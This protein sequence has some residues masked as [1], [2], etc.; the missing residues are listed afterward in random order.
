MLKHFNMER[1]RLTRFWTHFLTEAGISKPI[2]AD[3]ATSFS[4]H[5]IQENMI[6]NLNEEC[7]RDLGINYVGD[8]MAIHKHAQRFLRKATREKDMVTNEHICRAPDSDKTVFERLGKANVMPAPTRNSS[9][10]YATKKPI[11]AKSRI[12]DPLREIIQAK[13]SSMSMNRLNSNITQRMNSVTR[14]SPLKS[15]TKKPI[16]AKSRIFDPIRELIQTKESS[17]S[18]DWTTSC[19]KPSVKQRLGYNH[20]IYADHTMSEQWNLMNSFYLLWILIT[21]DSLSSI[22]F[23]SPLYY[24]LCGNKPS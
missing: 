23:V 12:F 10:K 17:M 15:A 20:S 21:V 5:R 16:A 8:V 2:A 4:G 19:V 13:Q 3:Y 11:A 9:Q 24:Y 7:L 6:L 14:N 1:S 18:M 22:C